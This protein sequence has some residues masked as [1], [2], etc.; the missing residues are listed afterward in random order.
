[1]SEKQKLLLGL[2]IP[3]VRLALLLGHLPA[4]IIYR[5]VHFVWGRSVVFHWKQTKFINI[6]CSM[7]HGKLPQITSVLHWN[8]GIRLKV[9]KTVFCNPVHCFN[10]CERNTGVLTWWFTFIYKQKIQHFA[11]DVFYPVVVVFLLLI[12]ARSYYCN[13]YVYVK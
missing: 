10:T 12:T 11:Y 9:K 8:T 7:I 13:Y 6:G 2:Q 1:M 5:R 3:F 4:I